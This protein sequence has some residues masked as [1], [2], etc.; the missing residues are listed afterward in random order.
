MKT[1]TLTARPVPSCLAYRWEADLLKGKSV[2]V[3]LVCGTMGKINRNRMHRLVL[4]ELRKQFGH[5]CRI[6]GYVCGEPTELAKQA[7]A[8]A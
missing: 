3:Q 2:T 8:K 6:G 5:L 4:P 7:G 1:F